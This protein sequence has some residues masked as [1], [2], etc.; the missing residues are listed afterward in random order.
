MWTAKSGRQETIRV[1]SSFD[2]S[3]MCIDVI[4]V[5]A[6]KLTSRHHRR[7][8]LVR[9]EVQEGGAIVVSDFVIGEDKTRLKSA[10]KSATERLRA[11]S[12]SS[13]SLFLFAVLGFR[14]DDAF[15][16]LGCELW[17]P[18]EYHGVL[19]HL[20]WIIPRSCRSRHSYFHAGQHNRLVFV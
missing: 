5:A 13:L 1:S 20:R 7:R 12:G 8:W 9:D 14:A 18:W 6:N 16:E 17:L 11:Y 15:S 10:A 2:I 19:L 4:N 3:Q